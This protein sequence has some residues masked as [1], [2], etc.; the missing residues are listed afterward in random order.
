MGVFFTPPG[1]AFGIEGKFHIGDST[2]SIISL[3]DDSFAIV[4]EY[5]GEAITPKYLAFY[6]PR[7]S[8]NQVVELFTNVN[9]N[10]SVPVNFSGLSFHWASSFM[11]CVVL[12]DGTLSDQGYGFSAT[13]NIFSFSF[14]GDMN[15][16]L[17]N[18]LTANV[19]VSPVTLGSIFKLTGDGKG[20]SVKVDKNGNPIKNNFVPVTQV[21]KDAVANAT[22]KQIVSVGGPSL[23][24][25]TLTLPILHLNAKA[26]LFDLANYDIEA[27]INKN[28]ISFLLDY[29]VVLKEKMSVVLSDFHNL[30]GSFTYYINQTITVP[31]VAGVK[32]GSFQLAAD[33]NVHFAIATSLTDVK[34]SV[35]GGFDFQGLSRSFGDFAADIN[36]TKIT[37]LLSAISNYIEQQARQVFSDFLNDAQQWVNKVKSGF[38]TGCDEVGTV[39]KDVWSGDS[40]AVA[41]IM[42]KAGYAIDDISRNIKNAWNCAT[43]DVTYAL[44]AVGYSADEIAVS[45]KN[46]FNA[47]S[48]DVAEAMKAMGFAAGDVAAAIKNCWNCAINDVCWAMTYVG[49]AIDDIASGLKT[50]FNATMQDA[51]ASLMQWV[52]QLAILVKL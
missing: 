15:V 37:D 24:I 35:G 32:L 33:V 23:I 18:G 34:L 43:T 47:A 31:T 29:G 40:I 46:V 5:V 10:I 48:Q 7:L 3:D 41:D 50:A 2:T 25:N 22:S 1:F 26:S 42:K 9:P 21:E 38:I 4:C 28:G 11:D 8:L 6:V 16:D 52:M 27:D 30:A 49:F 19:E 17:N 14:Y 13:A 12:P 45:L 39:I 36:I 51:A 20:F 44:K